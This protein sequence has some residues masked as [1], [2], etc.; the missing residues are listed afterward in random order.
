MCEGRGLWIG[1][2]RG[3]VGSGLDS[4]ISG[5]FFVVVVD[6]DGGTADRDTEC[7]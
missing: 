2:E 4:D 3:I 5:I 1:E 6:M 7:E